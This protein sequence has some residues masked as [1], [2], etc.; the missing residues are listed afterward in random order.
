MST[1]G[2]SKAQP[3]TAPARSSPGV[4]RRK[5]RTADFHQG[6][7]RAVRNTSRPSRRATPASGVEAASS[8]KT[9]RERWDQP[10]TSA[11][12]YARY[13]YQTA[14]ATA[15]TVRGGGSAASTRTRAPASA[16]RRAQVSPLTPAP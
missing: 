4:A 16:R 7:G 2:A 13:G 10:R 12:G 3:S 15:E 1:T 5:E 11:S 9:S 6:S 14:A 8:S